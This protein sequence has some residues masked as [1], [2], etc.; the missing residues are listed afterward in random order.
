MAILVDICNYYILIIFKTIV[1]PI[2][3]MSDKINL[4]RDKKSYS[5][6]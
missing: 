1:D 3:M 4:L 5:S 6:D 2:P